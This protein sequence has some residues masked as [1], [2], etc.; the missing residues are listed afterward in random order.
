MAPP[1]GN[2]TV[3]RKA[4]PDFRSEV[5]STFCLCYTVPK[6]HDVKKYPRFMS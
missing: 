6:L 3:N 2:N 4:D 1:S 5:C